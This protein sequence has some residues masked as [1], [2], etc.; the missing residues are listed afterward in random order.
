MIDK[1]TAITLAK[2]VGANVMK[3][4]VD[5]AGTLGDHLILCDLIQLQTLITRTQNKAFEQA[6]QAAV[7]C[8]SCTYVTQFDR[9]YEQVREALQ[10]LYDAMACHESTPEE[11]LALAAA[12][13]ALAATPEPAPMVRL[14]LA[15]RDMIATSCQ[16]TQ[17]VISSTIDA[18][19]AKNCGKHNHT[20]QQGQ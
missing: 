3:L 15:E 6:A 16:S 10:G 5:G 14:N 1:D 11:I 18:M 13:K 9:A 8:A 4:R 2:D 7:K 17:Q 19:I 12:E 20:K